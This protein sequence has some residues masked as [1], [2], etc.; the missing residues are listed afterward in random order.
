M[1]KQLPTTKPR[2]STSKMAGRQ[3]VQKVMVQPINLIFRFL[4]SVCL[5]PIY[6]Y[7]TFFP[8][9]KARVAVWLFEQVN[10]RIEGV[11]IVR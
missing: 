7:L 2:S 1:N 6:N 5:Q 4:Q 9:Q 8:T 10:D 3:K 11:I